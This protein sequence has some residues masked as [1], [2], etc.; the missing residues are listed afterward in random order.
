[1]Q[2]EQFVN[3]KVESGRYQTAIEM[4]RDGLRLLEQREL[5]LKRITFSTKED[6]E[7]MLEA[8]I[9]GLDAGKGIPGEVA[10]KSLVNARQKSLG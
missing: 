10:L 1:M 7:E 2:W 3:E 8:G 9:K 4:P 5:A 6:L